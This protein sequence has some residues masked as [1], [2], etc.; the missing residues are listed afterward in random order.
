MHKLQGIFIK[1]QEMLLVWLFY[2]IENKISRRDL[3][4]REVVSLAENQ[5]T[6]YSEYIDDIELE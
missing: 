6:L 4:S 1:L 2:K 3:P 5:V